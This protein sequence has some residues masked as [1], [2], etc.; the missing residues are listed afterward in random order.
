MYCSKGTDETSG[1]GAMKAI[2]NVVGESDG[3]PDFELADDFDI[4]YA[5]SLERNGKRSTVW[6]AD[7]N[8]ADYRVG[9]AGFSVSGSSISMTTSASTGLVSGTADMASRNG[10]LKM[11]T[12]GTR[13]GYL[14]R[15]YKES[16]E[17]GAFKVDSDLFRHVVIRK[18]H[19]VDVQ[20]KPV[21]LESVTLL[22][23]AGSQCGGTPDATGVTTPATAIC[24][25][26][27]SGTT[28]NTNYN[29]KGN[30][31]EKQVDLYI[32]PQAD[33]LGSY[34]TTITTSSGATLN[35]S[36]TVTGSAL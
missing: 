18:I 15:L 19:D 26:Y 22:S 2:F 13:N 32:V 20:F 30:P 36:W 28:V 11:T 8:S 34:D 16:G 17:S 12:S 33:K 27:S 3:Q 10:E 29:G 9:S 24:K 21:Y 25:S 4:A 6:S 7:G 14:F 1:H 31:G 5:E 35:T 23:G